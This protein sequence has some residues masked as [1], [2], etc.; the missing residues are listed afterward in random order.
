VKAPDD[1]M[2]GAR[3]L[4]AALR[5]STKDLTIDEEVGFLLLWRALRNLGG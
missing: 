1:L 4:K 5:G 2:P 3:A